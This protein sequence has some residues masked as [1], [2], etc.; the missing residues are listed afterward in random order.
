MDYA[1][2]TASISHSDSIYDW[3]LRRLRRISALGP[4]F[5]LHPAEG[6]SSTLLWFH[7]PIW[8]LGDRRIPHQARHQPFTPRLPRAVRQRPVPVAAAL[9]VTGVAAS[10]VIIEKMGGWPTWTLFPAIVASVLALSATV[11]G[12]GWLSVMALQPLLGS[13]AHDWDADPL[14][15]LGLPLPLRRKCEGLGFWTCESM[16]ESIEQGRFPWTS[17]EYAERMQVERALSLW[18][19]HQGEQ[20]TLAS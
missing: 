5:C 19:A 16:V 15:V 13:K 20:Q 3:Y 9:A 1:P 7:G 10:W 8:P 17:L 12:A 14:A 18:K 11:I 6:I 2:K 4:T